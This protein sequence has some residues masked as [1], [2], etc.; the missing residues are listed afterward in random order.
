MGATIDVHA[1]SAGLRLSM[2]LDSPLGGSAHSDATSSQ[3][4]PSSSSYEVVLGILA[5]ELSETTSACHEFS[6]KASEARDLAHR[7]EE[8]YQHLKSRAVAL[9]VALKDRNDRVRA[10]K[11]ESERQSC[12]RSISRRVQ[13]GQE[14]S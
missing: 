9:E 11:L 2:E 12:A 5:N 4:S 10:A 8:A 1:T 3:S 14:G 7:T 6:R 13:C